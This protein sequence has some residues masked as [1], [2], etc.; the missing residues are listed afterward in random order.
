MS[1]LLKYYAECCFDECRDYL[2]VRLSVVKLN[3]AIPNV[4][5]LNVDKLSVVAPY[6][7][8]KPLSTLSFI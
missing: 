2:N 3:V 6:H 5:L 1:L 7:C 4:V 8:T